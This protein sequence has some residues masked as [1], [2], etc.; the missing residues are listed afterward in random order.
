MPLVT[1]AALVQPRK[2]TIDGPEQSPD[3]AATR[4]KQQ[5]QR[6]P[7]KFFVLPASGLGA[8]KGGL[9]T[10]ALAALASHPINLHASPGASDL[11]TPLSSPVFGSPSSG[12]VRFSPFK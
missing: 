7:G 9:P 2:V 11:D 8:G 10:G 5:P 4:K 12:R 3:A 6:S 1:V